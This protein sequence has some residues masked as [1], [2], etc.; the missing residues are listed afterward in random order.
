MPKFRVTVTTESKY[1]MDV[2]AESTGTAAVK[3]GDMI[4]TGDLPPLVGPAIS[5]ISIIPLRGPSEE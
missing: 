3:V 4:R 1:V 5:D 2:E